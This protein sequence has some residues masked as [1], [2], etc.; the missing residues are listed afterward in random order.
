MNKRTIMAFIWRIFYSMG[1]VLVRPMRY[2][3][4]KQTYEKSLLGLCSNVQ[5]GAGST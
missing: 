3:R 2:F 1:I 4:Q 5:L